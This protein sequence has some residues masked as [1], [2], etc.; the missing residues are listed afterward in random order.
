MPPMPLGNPHIKQNLRPILLKGSEV[1]EPEAREGEVVRAADVAAV[2][3][4]A[5]VCE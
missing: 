3:L 5:P 4:T 1:H 2:G